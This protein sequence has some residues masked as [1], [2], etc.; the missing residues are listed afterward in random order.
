MFELI[1]RLSRYLFVFYIVYFL[2][3]GVRYIAYERGVWQGSAFLATS[4]QRIVVIFMHITAF[5][6][7][8]YEP[9]TFSFDYDAL[10]YAA[11]SLVLLIAM[12]VG[13][14]R[15]Y[16]GSCPLIW[17]GVYFLLTTG[18]IM[19]WRLDQSLASRQLIWFFV[20]AAAMFLMPLF[21]KLIP[22]F[23]KL[24]PLYLG[25]GLGLLIL[26][27]LIGTPEYGAL[28]SVRIGPM[29]FQPSE[30]VKFL[31]VFYLASAF[32]KNKGLKHTIMLCAVS[33]VYVGILVL[34]TDLGS[35]LIFFM[36]FM[37]VMYVATGSEILF[38]SGMGA[39]SL[40][41]MAAY[42][43]FGH[44][45]IRV[46]IW[47]DPW[48]DVHGIGHQVVQSLFA[49]STWGLLGSGLTLGMPN[50]IPV[51]A[52]DMM[53]AA[54]CEELGSLFGIGIIGVYIMIFYR[55]AHIALR[56]KRKYY[57]LLA[58][59]FTAMMAFQTFLILG[60]TINLIPLTG[61]TLPFVSYGGSSVLVSSLMIGI[62]QWIFMYYSESSDDGEEDY[63]GEDT[64]VEDINDE[65]D[66]DEVT[67]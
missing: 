63:E 62:I 55:G 46:A 60:G 38:F 36:T 1:I 39:M 49:I 57:S 16:K 31:F 53:F 51:V 21:L 7:L 52:R 12:N 8:A 2:W 66:L 47:Q 65:I 34:Q 59:G 17:N 40:A 24:E 45:R 44:V 64:E 23:E 67:P 42:R 4:K 18:L 28:R 32:R 58:V 13:A 29:N 41:S 10:I 43:L 14:G 48:T 22:K 25:V 5:L 15:I 50:R 56:C 35:A 3:Q 6:I 54:I 19:L 33:A 27:F 61:V 30:M 26:P 9:G 37:V 11:G 20:G